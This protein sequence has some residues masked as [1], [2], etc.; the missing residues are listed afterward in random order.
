MVMVKTVPEA[1]V[2]VISPLK[3]SIMVVAESVVVEVT[4]TEVLVGLEL[5]M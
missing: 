5:R 3:F 1:R 2:L 4:G